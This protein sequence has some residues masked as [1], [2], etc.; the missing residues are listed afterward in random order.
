MSIFFVV[1]SSLAK[2]S[3]AFG[4]AVSYSFCFVF[5]FIF[6]VVASNYSYLE[7]SVLLWIKCTLWKFLLSIFV[8]VWFIVGCLFIIGCNLEILW[9]SREDLFVGKRKKV[10]Y[11]KK[12]MF[13][14]L[15]G[16]CVYV[17]LWS[18]FFFSFVF[19]FFSERV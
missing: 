5:F 18:S 13:V 4:F 15:Q 19:L 11:T 1:I 3:A 8:L 7:K 17:I 2:S 16:Q 10:I 14:F 12:L 6:T 9:C